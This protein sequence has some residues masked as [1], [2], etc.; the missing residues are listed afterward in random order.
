MPT[1]SSRAEALESIAVSSYSTQ[2][3]TEPPDCQLNCSIHNV[4]M[5]VTC[6]IVWCSTANYIMV[7]VR[8][9][10]III[11]PRIII[12][13]RLLTCIGFNA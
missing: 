2:V 3:L 1:P 6:T 5:T 9:D 8:S 12:F 10:H 7:S 4:P 13:Q 11:V